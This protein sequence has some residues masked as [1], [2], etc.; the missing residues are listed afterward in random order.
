[1]KTI[2]ELYSDCENICKEYGLEINEEIKNIIINKIEYVKNR[3]QE[4]YFVAK[5]SIKSTD[6]KYPNFI[7]KIKT[8]TIINKFEKVQ[9]RML[10]VWEEFGKISFF[11]CL[12]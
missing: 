9:I 8:D 2:E 4:L 11:I 10:I 5:N 1:M 6:I 7:G 12:G 3:E